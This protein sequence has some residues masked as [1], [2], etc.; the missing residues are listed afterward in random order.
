[1]LSEIPA[2]MTPKR[3]GRMALK[4]RSSS[5]SL[6]KPKMRKKS[7]AT[8]EDI[9]LVAEQAFGRHGLSGARVDRMAEE[10]SVSKRMIY[11]YFKNKED[12][13][14]AVLER[15]Y[16][17]IRE[18]DANKGTLRLSPVDAIKAMVAATL[19]HEEA[20]PHF[21][22]IVAT[23]NLNRARFLKAIPGIRQKNAIIIDRIAETLQRG[24]DLG[25]FR[26]DVSALDVHLV[27]SALCI[28]RGMNRHTFE[29]LFGEN[30]FGA[31]FRKRYE[32]LVCDA[33]LGLL[34]LKRSL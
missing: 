24:R 31:H 27:I 22:P 3:V 13:Y 23:E 16:L 6:E 30:I 18:H 34:A 33:V 25:Q 15:C 9:L 11:Y 20:H 5:R 26:E 32:D 4:H 14:Q 12:L 17:S 7:E 29:I 8:R 1:M 21:A 19:D 2:L 10:M 28:F